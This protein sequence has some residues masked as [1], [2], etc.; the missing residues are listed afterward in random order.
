MQY[1][2]IVLGLLVQQPQLHVQLKKQHKLLSTMEGY[3]MEL[4][5]KHEAWKAQ[6]SQIRPPGTPSQIASEAMEIAL[7]DLQKQ[8]LY[9]FPPEDETRFRWSAAM[10][11]LR[12][13]T[14]PA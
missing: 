13:H 3:A 11:F 9:E 2:T 4:R 12:R 1:K 10:T 14:P 5:D 7:E 8:L 6:L